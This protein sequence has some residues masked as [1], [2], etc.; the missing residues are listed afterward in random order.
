M[1]VF[2]SIL[3]A[4]GILAAT[5]AAAL[6]ADLSRGQM[7]A[8]APE[9]AAPLPG[10]SGWI[11]SGVVGGDWNS[12]NFTLGGTPLNATPSNV[13]FGGMSELIYM[14]NPVF[15]VEHKLM[16]RYGDPSLN[17]GIPRVGA[18]GAPYWR[19]DSFADVV[20]S[21]DPH[22]KVDAGV[23]AA[24]Q[25]ENVNTTTLFGTGIKLQNYGWAANAGIEVKPFIENH[26]NLAFSVN[27]VYE[28]MNGFQIGPRSTGNNNFGL[29]AG[30]GW[31]F[32]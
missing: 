19:V 13:A 8:K 12:V 16:V 30:M 7:P 14:F 3:A 9:F 6:S 31:E 18:I 21:W 25:T 26:N 11:V 23:G 17:F 29:F 22:W 10:W 24:A 2:S 27:F 32:Q 15:G 5:S 28:N 1:K 20:L 4:A